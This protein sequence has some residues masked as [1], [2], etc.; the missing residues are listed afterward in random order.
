MFKPVKAL[1]SFPEEEEKILDFWE[2]N[3]I[4]EK[5]RKMRKGSP[6]FRWLEGPPTA[7]GLPHI[8]HALTRAIK[9][10]FL[11]YKSMHGYEVVPWVA[12]WDCHGLPVELEVEK[13]LGFTDKKQIEEFGLRKFNEECR[14]S[15]FKYVKEWQDMSRRIGFWLDFD[16]RYATLDETYVESVW[17]SIKEIHKKGLLYL[18]YKV[19]PYCPRCGTPL[20]SHE[21]GQGMMETTDPSVYVKF[22]AL[23]F[24]DT[25]YLAWTT[26]PWTLISNICLTVNPEVDYVQVEYNG[27]KLILAESIAEKLLGDFT[28]LQK[29]KGK[30]LE[31]NKYEQLFPFIVPKVEAFYVTLANYVTTEEG[32]GIVH[33]APAFGEDDAEIGKKYGLPVMNPVL[34]DGTFSEDIKDFAGLFVKDADS[35][36]MENLKNRKLLFKK[37]VYKHTY[38]F[39]YRCDGPLLYYSTETWYIEMSR[40]RDKLVNN[41]NQIKWQ[42]IHLKNGRFGNFISE[43]RDWALSRNRYW[44]TP[45]PIWIC[46]N[47][48]LT[49]VGSLEELKELY[50]KPLVEDFSLH[51]PWVDDIKFNCPECQKLSTRVPYVIDCWYD[52]GSA[53]FAQYHYPF[54][55]KNLFNEHFPYDFITEAIDQTRGWFYTLLA[56]S[57]VL[58]DKPA[59]MSCLTMGHTLDSKG[60]KMSKSKGNMIRADDVIPKYGADAVRWFLY[61]YPTW[62]SVRVDPTQIYET[63]KKFILTLWNSYSFFVSNA[64]VDEFNT[65]TFNVPLNERTELDKWLISELNYLIKAIDEA[66]ENMTVHI[67]VQAFENFVI[68]KFSNWFL[69]Q[70]RRRFWKSEL[71]KDKKSA[72]ITSYEVLVVLSKLLA[73][74]IPFIA[75]QLHHNL[76][77]ELDKNASISVHL[78]A[79]PKMDK[80]QVNTQLSKEMNK[81]LSLVTAGRSIR[82]EANIKLRQ[83]LSELIIISPLGEKDLVAKYEEVLKEE[84]NV[85]KITLK[86]SSE[87][88]VNY[89]IKPN[90][91]ILAPKVKSVVNDIRNRLEQLNSE[92]SRELVELIAKGESIKLEVNGKEHKLYPEDLEYKINVHEGFAGEETEGYLLLFNSTI[93]EDLKKEGY[94]R[95]IIRRVQTMR[96]ELDLEYTQDVELSILADDFGSQAIREYDE[97]IKGETLAIKLEFEEPKKGLV[98]EWKFDEYEVTIGVNPL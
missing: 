76:V 97:Y 96:K 77:R 13:N 4:F 19:V 2:K 20:S 93:T 78:L 64:N 58:F 73:P 10:V 84:L 53:P 71:D 25:Y 32:T 37:G 60:K 26:T 39:C 80:K 86:K 47:N 28:V 5:L 59:Y 3:E 6:L 75:E 94:V 7:N 61:S 30:D 52:A 23:D 55:N 89:V 56:I 98:K 70:S 82:S 12:G 88:L 18:G 62:N 35:K 40:M 91:K 83:P 63:M 66:L 1:P 17:W 48:H 44:G 14:K 92:K 27:E 9:D 22:K 29:F 42:P 45:L 85:K 57:T 46:E 31:Y 67:A 21:V 79:Y 38:P 69:R 95:D 65:E 54:E 81:V 24:K 34:E 50:G 11:R 87:E 51:R 8:G 16:N 41:N 68:D 90:F 33:S 49:V 72:Y 74:F 43:V 15:V 36:I